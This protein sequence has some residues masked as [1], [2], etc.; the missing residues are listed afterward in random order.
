M[1]AEG[2][3]TQDVA[4][5]LP[6]AG[7]DRAQGYLWMRPAPWTEVADVRPPPERPRRPRPHRGR[8]A[9]V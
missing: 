2:V 1:T 8:E 5:W 3:E 9:Q 7:C 4:D 6:D